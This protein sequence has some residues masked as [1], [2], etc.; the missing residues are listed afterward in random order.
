MIKRV[1]FPFL[2]NVSWYARKHKSEMLRSDYFS[3]YQITHPYVTDR[4]VN[5]NPLTHLL[6]KKKRDGNIYIF[7]KDI[8]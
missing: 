4:S 3:E 5:Q 1:Y 2:L 8:M 6:L 7:P